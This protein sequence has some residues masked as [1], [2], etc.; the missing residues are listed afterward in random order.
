MA[1][2]VFL[3]LIMIMALGAGAQPQMTDTAS[4]QVTVFNEKQQA[5]EG[6]TIE[7]IRVAN[8]E[9]VKAAVTDTNGTAAFSSILPGEHYFA[10]SAAGYEAQ[11]TRIYNFPQDPE[12]RQQVVLL[13]RVADMQG[14]TVVSNRPF[15]QYQQGKTIINVDAAITNVGTTVLEL[16]EKSPGVMVD[17][18]GTISLLAKTGVLVMIDDKPTYL[19]G[20][21][22]TNFLSSMSS[23][24][25]DQV[26]L[27]PTPPAKYDASG[28]AGIINIRT[29][30][31]KQK[32]FNGTANIS[33][34]QGR[35]PKSNNSI[36]LNYRNGKFNSF[37]NYSLNYNKYFS[38]LYALRTYYN[39]V[40]RVLAVLDQPTIFTG[41]ILN[42]TLK[43]GMDYYA[44]PNTTIGISLTGMSVTRNGDS[45]ASA[46][47]KDESGN[48][49][50]AIGTYSKTANHFKNGALNLNLKHV[51]NPAQDLSID[52]DWL[53][54]S[55]SSEQFFNNQLLASGGY[56]ELSKGTIPSSIHILSAKSDYKLLIGKESKLEA[57]WK[58]SHINTDNLA[59]YQVY[60]GSQ[61][62]D[63]L[64]KSNHFLY[65]ENIHALY[66]SGE[67]KKGR[68]SVQGGLRYEYT[69]YVANQL[70]NTQH[71]DSSFSSTYQGFFPSGY[72]NYQADSSNSFTFTAGRRI[73]RPPF[74]KLNPFV[75][76]INKYTYETGN[77]YYKPQY[78]WNLDLSH[79]YKSILTT[80]VSYSTI[81]N[82]FSQL[83]LTDSSGIL[84]YSEGNVGRV[85]NLG[86]S[87]S[88]QLELF[89]W[90]SITGTAV[91]NHK[92]LK[93]Y[94][95]KNYASSI[96]QMNININNQ[97]RFNKTYTGEISGYYITKARNDLQELLYPTGQLSVGISRPLLKNKATLKLSVRD[98]FYTQTME[99]LTQFHSAE[100]YFIIQRDSRVV[101]LAFS[102]RFGKSLKQVKRGA[103]GAG[104]EMERVGNGT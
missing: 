82:Y 11:A 85:K 31:G 6:V 12:R 51:I 76:I 81:K 46:T 61:W 72:F 92:D 59:Y 99:G 9:L 90:W 23:S 53:N 88:L 3:L 32:G 69:N 22:L 36:I 87:V 86:L 35:Y 1:R 55:I 28:N 94:A 102:W 40:G 71:R 41:N 57:G 62:N 70:G 45:N 95:G 37:L 100:E 78:S 75:F 14:V 83:F 91:Y 48:V 17:R 64:G 2:N 80:A 24:Q 84:I 27:M 67:T 43:A 66:A 74:Q 16:L 44:S 47:W 104:D 97:F 60:H 89:K 96:D 26:E 15:I 50:S 19:S 73:D 39:S 38:D 8:K 34:G 5:A 42:N 103:G 56:T 54:Y 49:D 20:T 18:N 98:I 58:S 93:G 52:V 7:L 21:E 30:K 68:I 79:Q 101:S 29:K 13:P 25:V 63:D 77:P 10:I 65:R 33:A 4:F